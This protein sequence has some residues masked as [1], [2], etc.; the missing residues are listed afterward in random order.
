[1][2]CL[3]LI[4]YT[5]GYIRVKPDLVPIFVPSCECCRGAANPAAVWSDDDVRTIH[6]MRQQGMTYQAIGNVWGVSKSAI[7]NAYVKRLPMLDA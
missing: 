6:E 7:R 1:M 4:L 5:P 3:I 2:A